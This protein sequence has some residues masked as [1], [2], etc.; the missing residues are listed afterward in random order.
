MQVKLQNNTVGYFVVVNSC[1]ITG[2]NFYAGQYI[3][4]VGGRFNVSVMKVQNTIAL[5]FTSKELK[6]LDVR[7]LYKNEYNKYFTQQY[8]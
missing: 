4:V 3:W 8:R 7:E 1:K 2:V 6:D 5:K